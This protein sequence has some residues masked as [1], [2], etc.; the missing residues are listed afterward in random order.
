[1]GKRAILLFI[2]TAVIIIGFGA[3]LNGGGAG[4]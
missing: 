2:A 4:F 1:M 3:A